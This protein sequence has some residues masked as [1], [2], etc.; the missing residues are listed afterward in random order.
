MKK[1]LMTVALASVFV[2]TACSEEAAAL[3]VNNDYTV[4]T[5]N[6]TFTK[7]LPSDTNTV[8]TPERG[9]KMEIFTMPK[10]KAK[11]STGRRNCQADTPAPRVTTSS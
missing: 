10:I 7:L 4:V 8:V 5:P 3:T 2:L 6:A 9:L 1:S 11:T